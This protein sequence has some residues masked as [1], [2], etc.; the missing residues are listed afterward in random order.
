M[1]HSLTFFPKAAFIFYFFFS[2]HL[3]TSHYLILYLFRAFFM[4]LLS[5]A[6]SVIGTPEG[7]LTNH[8]CQL[9]LFLC[10]AGV[11][12]VLPAAAQ[13]AGKYWALIPHHHLHQSLQQLI[14]FCCQIF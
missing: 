12:V 11:C 14:D 3:P 13:L 8:G 9:L 4:S 10:C 7:L 6:V 5:F 1:R 2:I